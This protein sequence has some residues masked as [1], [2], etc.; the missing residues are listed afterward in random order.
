MTVYFCLPAYNEEAG[1]GDLLESIFIAFRDTQVDYKAVVI[2]DGSTDKTI[3]VLEH[4]QHILPLEILEHN[5]NQGLRAA[6]NSGM[7]Y[8][9]WNGEDDDILICMDADN[10]H[11]PSVAFSMID[12]IREGYDIVIASR[13]LPD[14]KVVGVPLPR[15][16]LSYSARICFHMMA[17]IKGVKDFTCGFRA[18]RLSLIKEA[19]RYYNGKFITQDGFA[20]TDEILLKSARLTDKIA[21]VPFT[22]RYDLK[23]T[24][25]KL[26]L[27]LTVRETLKL[28]WKSRKL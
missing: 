10:T 2:N 9:G 23:K 13:Y 6:L 14:S 18:F 24:S 3:E 21:E 4:Y 22:L 20:C 12:K 27:G 17:P 5:E 15:L 26:N 11:S 7:K 1:I 8:I 28:L 19:Y 16:F 25:S